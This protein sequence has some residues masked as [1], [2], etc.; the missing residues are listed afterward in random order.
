[1][2]DIWRLPGPS[3]F[4]QRLVGDLADGYVV[5]LQRPATSLAD[6]VRRACANELPAISFVD[7]L[8]V[9]ASDPVP[10][11]ESTLGLAP[12]ADDSALLEAMSTRMELLWISGLEALPASARQSWLGFIHRIAHLKRTSDKWFPGPVAELCCPLE[13]S[14]SVDVHLRTHVWSGVLHPLDVTLH[15]AVARPDLTPLVRTQLVELCRGDLQLADALAGQSTEEPNE[16]VKLCEKDAA[17]KNLGDLTEQARVHPLFGDRI[18]HALE[19]AWIRGA[20]D[21]CDG[22]LSWHPGL[23]PEDQVRQRLWRGQLRELLPALD[24][25]RR[26]LI[27]MLHDRHGYT[28]VAFEDAWDFGDLARLLRHRRAPRDAVALAEALREARNRLAHLELIPLERLESITLLLKRAGVET[29][30]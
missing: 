19:D 22:R 23:L 15:L 27:A 24:D 8:A 12:T 10:H 13:G 16:L 4:V 30:T 26:A 21:H 11:V 6:D 9:D 20:V 28:A 1:M 25:W 5:V 18:P 2:T 17:D 3:R 7:L 29:R 14:P